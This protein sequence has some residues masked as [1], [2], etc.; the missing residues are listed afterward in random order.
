MPSR[1]S[2]R[3]D[4]A[5][6]RQMVG[7]DAELALF[8]SALDAP[9]GDEPFVAL[10]LFGPGGVGKSTLLKA[11][12]DECASRGVPCT[13]LDVHDADPSPAGFLRALGAA[14]RL[15][16]GADPLAALVERGGKD[17]A[18][19]TLLIDGFEAVAALEGWLRDTFL[20]ELPGGCVTV[21]AGRTPPSAA[22]RGDAAWQPL[23]RV[24]SL[25]NLSPD[26]ARRLLTDRGVPEDRHDAVLGF[27]HGYPLA[28]SLVSDV[29]AQRP[30]DLAGLGGGDGDELAPPPDVV[31][32]L[33]ERFADRTPTAR[34]RAA[35]EACAL[36]RVTTEPALARLLDAD[37]VPDGEGPAELFDWLNA[38][39]FVEAA[40]PG[41]AP[42]AVARAAL[43][44]DLRWRSP[45]RYADLHRRARAYYGD[46][47]ADPETPEAEQQRLLWD[48]IFLHRDNAVVRSAFTWEDAAAVYA[49]APRPGEGDALAAMVE[50]HEGP[51]SAAIF[52][53]WWAQPAAKRRAVVFRSAAAPDAP[54]PEG[55]VLLVNLHEA[56]DADRAADPAAA[57]ALGYLDAHAPL[58][59]GEA[60]T[61][62]R[63][64]MAR[65]T[66]HTVSPV[67]SL[68]VVNAVRHYLTTPG[69][70]ATFFPVVAP[71]HWMAAFTYAEM[72]RAPEADFTVG[73]RT[74]GVFVNDWRALPPL[75]WLSLLAEKEIAGDR[76][77]RE[78]AGPDAPRPPAAPA[79]EPLVVLSEPEFAAAVRD[80]L[81][82]LTRAE[83]LVK[84]PLLR[85]RV[86]AD[87]L[88]GG[89]GTGATQPTPLER[90]S[91]LQSV[92]REA[93]QAL[94]GA[95]KQERA[96]R[97]LHHTFLKPAPTQER[98]AEILDL[99]FSTYRRHLAEGIAL[100]VETL[101]QQEI[102]AALK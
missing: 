96:Y 102:G 27:T 75:A 99:P 29:Y 77:R 86:V 12:A 9:P 58:R 74:Y 25:R 53:H 78:A 62:F 18:R 16:A 60:A 100:V 91:V 68:I 36:L 70:A 22:W 97:A 95:A 19:Q 38:L 44:A 31:R 55:F 20:P 14:L 46:R 7:R 17:D 32:A 10:A 40:R 72:R 41:V 43:M 8:R 28:L 42:H 80:A 82:H 5:R 90:A 13:L 64:W 35:L 88:R 81:K 6:R 50:R 21:L 61:H 94:Q 48:F 59:R 84:N 89:P 47:L 3:L 54:D 101:W 63:F 67:Q 33:L 4:A 1:I 85:S 34:H 76:M 56:D 26:E 39:S 71:D 37:D 65:D 57:A 2:D 11:Y 73:E 83:S 92:L 24:V 66:Y 45:D 93:A 52:R 98:A 23:L 15:P 69:L 87:R 51:E 30:G 79:A 49:D